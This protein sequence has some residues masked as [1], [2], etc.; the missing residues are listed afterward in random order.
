MP[1]TAENIHSCEHSLNQNTG[2]NVTFKDNFW[3]EY[4]EDFKIYF[5]QASQVISIMT[6]SL[7]S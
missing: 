2:V 3:Q 7:T 1:N 4:S 6:M 5:F